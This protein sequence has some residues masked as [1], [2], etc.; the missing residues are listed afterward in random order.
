MHASRA[1]LDGMDRAGR[2]C[3]T[4]FYSSMLFWGA[5]ARYSMSA[6]VKTSCILAAAHLIAAILPQQ[7][8]CARALKSAARRNKRTYLYLAEIK[9]K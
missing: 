5:Q 3:F 2:R 8:I 7:T 9:M 1:V 6:V 4:V